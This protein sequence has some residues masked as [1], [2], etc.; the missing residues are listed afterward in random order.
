[1]TSAANNMKTRNSAAAAKPVGF[2]PQS[3]PTA[4]AFVGGF[5]ST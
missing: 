2:L 5:R 3:S 4:Q 1:M